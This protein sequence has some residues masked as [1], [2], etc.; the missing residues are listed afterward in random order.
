[1]SLS[2]IWGAKE[3]NAAN[4]ASPL[5]SFDS[6]WPGDVEEAMLV[7]HHKI[8]AMHDQY[9]D[10]ETELGNDAMRRTTDLYESAW[11]A[12]L[13]LDSEFF[14]DKTFGRPMICVTAER[15]LK[16]T[17]EEW[18]EVIARGHSIPVLEDLEGEYEPE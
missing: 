11:N 10:E 4:D 12:V 2:D 15:L 1:M 6:T 16:I 8:V 7:I 5:R 9:D 3:E 18:M 17:N 13:N 14:S